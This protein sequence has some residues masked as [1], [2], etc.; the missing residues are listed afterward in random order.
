MSGILNDKD[1]I[2]IAA[3]QGD[4]TEEI[5]CNCI[6]YSGNIPMMKWARSDKSSSND[7]TDVEER[8]RKQLRLTPFPWDTETCSN[9]A[10]FGHL[11]L[12]KWIHEQGC[13]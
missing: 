8:S 2:E 9:A 4:E 10:K 11:Q 3:I 13:P 1:A 6:A 7:E 12:L 5:M